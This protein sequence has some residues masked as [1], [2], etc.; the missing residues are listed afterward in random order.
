ME[1]FTVA[2]GLSSNGVA[3]I[4]EDPLGRIYL[5]TGHGV[6]C[7]YP[8]APPRIRHYTSADG[9]SRGEVLAAFC[10][11]HGVLWFGTR[12]GLSRLEP[13][14]ERPQSPPPVLI[15]GLRVRGAPFPISSLGEVSLSGIELSAD[16]N[17]LGLDFVDLAFGAGGA[18]RYQYRLEGAGQNWS[19][20][21]DQRTVNYAN[22]GPGSYRWQVRA[23]TADGIPSQPATVAFTIL[24]PL[25]QRW[26]V[27]LLLLLAACAVL[28]SLY[29]YRMARLLGGGEAADADRHRPA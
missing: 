15:S 9:L 27:Q 6:D 22:L 12:E 16:R 5:G 21:T 8:G 7:V 24:A 17:Q 11:R 3:S 4:T 26:W 23:V 19:P 28:Y 18:L 13:E 1:A 25:W 14:P 20:D 29:R 2:D 10:D